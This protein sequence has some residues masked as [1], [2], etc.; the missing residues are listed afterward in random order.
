MGRFSDLGASA[1]DKV[2][3]RFENQADRITYLL[4]EYKSA[5]TLTA[6]A[7]LILFASGRL[8]LPEI[9]SWWIVVI[10]GVAIGTIP[11]AL[12]S[13]AM[14]IDRFIPDP[15]LNIGVV[16]LPNKRIDVEKVDRNLWNRRTPGELPAWEPEGDIDYVV[17]KF[18][19]LEDVGELRIEGVNRELVDPISMIV[20]DKQIDEIHEDLQYRAAELDRYKARERTRRIEHDR[21]LVSSLMAAVEHGLEFEPGTMDAIQEDDLDEIEG[22]ERIEKPTRS[23]DRAE[24]TTLN[25]I[26][27]YTDQQPT[28]TDPAAATDGGR[29]R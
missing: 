25:E 10:E 29:D 11:S 22:S 26:L 9:P 8:G 7:V 15:R 23:D 16:D 27:G 6:I 21:R 28:G 4:G 14:I 5:V 12:L 2:P 20:R 13:K 18:E 17:S 1:P 19:Y 24:P 3:P